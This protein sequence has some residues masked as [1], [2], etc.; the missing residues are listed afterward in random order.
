MVAAWRL[1]TR[2]VFFLTDLRAARQASA[3]LFAVLRRCGRSIAVAFAG[4]H[5]SGRC[6]MPSVAHRT[7]HSSDLTSHK[8]SGGFCDTL[9]KNDN[10]NF[11]RDVAATGEHR[12]IQQR[13]E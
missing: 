12:A 8:L 9:S 10:G 7:R 6:S 11:S 4:R 3:E 13:A 2:V 1:G 5:D